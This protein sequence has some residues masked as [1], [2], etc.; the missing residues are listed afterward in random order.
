MLYHDEPIWDVYGVV[1][2]PETYEVD[3][4]ATRKLRQPVD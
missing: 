2:K 3:E 4:E 1:I